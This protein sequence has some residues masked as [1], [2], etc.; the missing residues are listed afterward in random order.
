[1]TGSAK[2]FRAPHHGMWLFYPDMLVAVFGGGCNGNRIWRSSSPAF[3]P[4]VLWRA[5]TLG[6]VFG[7][8]LGFSAYKIFGTRSAKW[9]GLFV[10]AFRGE[11]IHAHRNQFKVGAPFGLQ[12]SGVTCAEGINMPNCGV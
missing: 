8:L 4:M 10:A 11:G 6:L 12:M 5:C 1:M 7:A 9:I 2:L 3:D